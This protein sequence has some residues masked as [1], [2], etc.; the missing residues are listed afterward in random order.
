[1]GRRD[2]NSRYGRSLLNLA[3]GDLSAQN[4]PPKLTSEKCKPVTETGPLQCSELEVVLPG[5]PR[6]MEHFRGEMQ[7]THFASEFSLQ[8]SKR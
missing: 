7:F 4:H 3:E 8:M 5:A 1:M 6:N 2:H